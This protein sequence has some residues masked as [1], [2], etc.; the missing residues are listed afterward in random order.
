M[1]DPVVTLEQQ[2]ADLAELKA[3]TQRRQ[4][5]PHGTP[6]WLAAVRDET[7][8]VARIRGWSQAAERRPDP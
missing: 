6:E 2:L 8:T 4:G 3:A 1:D 5:L 7:E